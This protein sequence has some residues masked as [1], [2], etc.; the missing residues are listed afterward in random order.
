MHKKTAVLV[1]P[2]N[3]K[4]GTLRIGESDHDRHIYMSRVLALKTSI[5]HGLLHINTKQ[6]LQ[7]KWT[8]CVH[9]HRTV[10]TP[11]IHAQPRPHVLTPWI[12]KSSTTALL[13]VLVKYQIAEALQNG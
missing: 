5:K 3:A 4:I 8:V 1:L 13:S 11:Q 9:R 12:T 10:A 6:I 2:N 7:I